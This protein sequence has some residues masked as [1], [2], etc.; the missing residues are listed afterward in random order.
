MSDIE[1]AK[2]LFAD[3]EYTCVL[4]RNGAVVTRTERGIKPLIDF[5]DSGK[6]YCGFAAAD[7]I[8]G[9]AAALLYVRLGIK[10]LYAET[11][12]VAAKDICLRYGISVEY[13]TLTDGIVNRRGDGLCPMEKAV[14]NTDDPNDA[15]IAVK[16]ALDALRQKR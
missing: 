1:T 6:D 5:I 11:L 4:C 13:G 14:E 12:G 9:K 2:K 3:G 8:V 10:A 7:K 16:A 15:Y